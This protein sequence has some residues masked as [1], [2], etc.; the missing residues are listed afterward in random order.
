MSI[1][2]VSARRMRNAPGKKSGVRDARRISAL[3]RAGLL[4]GSFIPA[5]KQRGLRDLRRCRKKIIGWQASRK[6]RRDK[7]PQI[8]GFKISSAISDI[9]GASGRILIGMP[10]GAGEIPCIAASRLCG[11]AGKKEA[12]IRAS[13]AGRLSR[14]GS[15]FLRMRLSQ[16]DE[17]TRN[18]EKI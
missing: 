7:F 5:E 12:A 9:F 6:N 10:A 3:L 2:A 8:K 11:A 1:L 18:I 13:P 15:S 4:R 16:L 17:S 14:A